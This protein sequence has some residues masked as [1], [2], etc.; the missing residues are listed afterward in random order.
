MRYW[1]KD[2]ETIAPAELKRVQLQRLRNTIE[3]ALRSP[4]YGSG[5]STNGK[6][7]GKVRHMEDLH[8][9]P[10]TT[11]QHLRDNFPYGFLVLPKKDIIRL[12]VKD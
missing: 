11:K 3:G 10:F 4:F 8:E 12:P 2:I 6:F 5:Y 9:M 1:E 7:A